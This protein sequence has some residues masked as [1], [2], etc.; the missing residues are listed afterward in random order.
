MTI[1][2]F[3]F[4]WNSLRH[5]TLLASLF[6]YNFSLLVSM[7]LYSFRVFFPPCFL[8]IFFSFF[9][10]SV[11]LLSLPTSSGRVS[12]CELSQ[13]SPFSDCTLH[14]QF[15][16]LG[17]D[18]YVRNSTSDLYRAL[19]HSKPIAWW[20]SQRHTTSTSNSICSQ[21]NPLFSSQLPFLPPGLPISNYECFLNHPNGTLWGYLCLLTHPLSHS[22]SSQFLSS[23]YIFSVCRLCIH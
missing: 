20:T 7:I 6:Y 17:Y 21:L 15:Y 22:N 8:G 11:G 23:N 4:S 19:E 9:S 3:Q 1:F 18:F 16:A 14:K 10:S 5:S 2:F 12:Q 13:L